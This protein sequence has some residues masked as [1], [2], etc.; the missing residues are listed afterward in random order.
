MIIVVL[1]NGK[2]QYS[3]YYLYSRYIIAIIIVYD[4]YHCMYTHLILC[5]S[6]ISIDEASSWDKI[7]HTYMGFYTEMDYNYRFYALLLDFVKTNSNKMFCYT[8][9]FL[10]TWRRAATASLDERK[11]M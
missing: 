8:S 9:I 3:Y 7:I 11:G 10:S 6:K 4:I 2:R 5:A 1:N